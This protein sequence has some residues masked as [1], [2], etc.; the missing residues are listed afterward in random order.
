MSTLVSSW[1]EPR[2]GRLLAAGLALQGLVVVLPALWSA[3]HVLLVSGGLLLAGAMLFSVRRTLVVLV[4][5]TVAL[6]DHFIDATR[7]PLG[8]RPGELVLLAALGFACIDLVY[9]RGLGVT[10]SRPGGL[11]ALFLAV[12]VLSIFVGLY[13]G[14]DP[15]TVLRNARFPLY[16]AVFFAALQ[17]LDARDAARL[18]VP[19][20]IAAGLAVSAE[21]ILG[22]LGAIDLSSGNR[23]VR[24]GQRQ[25]VFLPVS[26][27]LLANVWLHDPRR[28]G[29]A[30]PLGLFLVMGVAFALTLGR[31]MW[32]AFGVG[33]IVT[34]WLREA[35]LPAA[36][37]RLWRGALGAVVLLVLLAGAILAFQRVTG[38]SISA[39]AAERSRSFVDYRRD[40]QVLGRILNYATAV[41][42]IAAH[43]L[44]GSGQGTTLT[45]YS[46]NPDTGRFETW[47]SWTID[48]LYLT[49]WV[50]MGLAGL[51][52]FMALCLR[53]LGR[54]HRA[55]HRCGDSSMRAFAAA[56]TAIMVA[57]LVLGLS[58]GSMVNGRFAMVFGVLFAL[59]ARVADAADGQAVNPT[60]AELV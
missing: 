30:V 53:V 13:R 29:R 15:S 23:F 9:R 45:S 17:V 3:Q 50:K 18:F 55:F 20:F 8:L 37:R 49:L 25:G 21:Y 6:P 48:S 42:A 34:V 39:H 16:Y 4:L 22:F 58:D 32:V 1:L 26:L 52:V 59:V 33:L 14:N 31:G 5:V 54:A 36:R 41:E 35:G 57:M 2:S 28:W 44:L 10:R 38:A 7:L 60:G 27:L 11:V 19:V 12:A 56:A 43:P 46:Y 40:V 24:L 51:I 47:S